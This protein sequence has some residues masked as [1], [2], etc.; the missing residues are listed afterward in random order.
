MD[1]VPCRKCGAPTAFVI[2]AKTR[3]GILVD[4]VP[5]QDYV[6]VGATKAGEPLVELHETWVPHFRACRRPDA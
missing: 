4:A 2:D 5:R 6:V 1:S 3:K